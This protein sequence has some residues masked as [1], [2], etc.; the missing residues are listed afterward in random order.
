[1]IHLIPTG[2][3]IDGNRGIRDPLGMY[4][5]QLGVSVHVVTAAAAAVRNLTTAVQRC[6]LEPAAFVVSPYAAGLA[7]LVDDEMDLGV[8]VVDMGGGTTTIAVFYEGNVIYTDIVPVGGIHV[9]NDVARG[10]S[11]SVAHAERIKTLYGHAMSNPSD[12][13]EMIDVPQ[14]GESEEDPAHQV[15]RSLLIGIMQPRLEETLELVRARL[16]TSGFDKI[17]GRRVVLVGGACQL[18]GLREL[19]TLIL[20]KQVH[21]GRPDDKRVVGLAEATSG[22]GYAACAG[23][24]LYALG[25]QTGIP[26]TQYREEKQTS[27]LMVRLGSWFRAHF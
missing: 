13:R 27:G 14:I 20:D 4:G 2:Y 5:D 6:H 1:M 7:A 3:S 11:T 16:E 9:T 26:Q 24:L 10:L 25:E 18:P 21:T 19:A 22:P 23:L 17:A 15:P 12:E 8:T